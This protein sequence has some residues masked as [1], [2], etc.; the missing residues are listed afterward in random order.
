LQPKSISNLAQSFKK[1]A[2]SQEILTI[3]EHKRKPEAS[4]VKQDSVIRDSKPKQISKSLA[5]LKPFKVSP[6]K[7]LLLDHHQEPF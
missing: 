1:R 5:L 6:Y 4:K 7:P 3:P 2:L